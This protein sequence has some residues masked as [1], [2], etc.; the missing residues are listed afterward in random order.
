[1]ARTTLIGVGLLGACAL[2]L[3]QADS[4]SPANFL[5]GDWQGQRTLLHEQGV[6]RSSPMSMSWPTTP[7]AASSTRAHTAIS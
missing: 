2:P 4:Y 7:R 3:A 5:F 6:D 1:M